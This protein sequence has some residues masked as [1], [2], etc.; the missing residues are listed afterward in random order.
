MSRAGKIPSSQS[1]WNDAGLLTDMTTRSRLA[2][3]LAPDLHV[4][5]AGMGHATLVDQQSAAQAALF[6]GRA[7]P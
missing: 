1:R 4:R 7:T 5:V 3:C 2:V 6:G